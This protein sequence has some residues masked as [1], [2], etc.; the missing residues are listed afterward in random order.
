MEEEFMKINLSDKQKKILNYII[1]A[2]TAIASIAGV[3]IA[4]IDKN[5]LNKQNN[6]VV[7]VK[8]EP[9]QPVTPMV[10]LEPGQGVIPIVV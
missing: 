1:V 4:A 9:A 10:N 6:I 7:V 2:L 5:L 8:L 3:T